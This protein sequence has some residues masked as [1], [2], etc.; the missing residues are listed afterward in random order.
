MLK[1]RKILFPFAFI[2]GL[3]TFVRNV[4]YDI[5]ILKSH[6]FNVPTI[7]VGNLSVGGTGKSPQV[8]YLIKLLSANYQV[9]TLSRGYKR[10]T[11]GFVLA[12]DKATAKIIGDE[13][14]QFYSKF[15]KTIVAVDEKR[16]EGIELLM[17]L[18]KKPDVIILDDA[19]QHRSVKAGFYIL[20]TAYNDLFCD[21]FMLPSGNLREFEAGKKRSDVVVV[22]KCPSNL[23]EAS[24]KRIISRLKVSV[25]VYFTSIFYDDFV[26]NQDDKSIP[27]E[28]IINSE[29]I[30]VAGIANPE[31]FFK[32]LSAKKTET[33]TF[34]DHHSFDTKDLQ[35]IINKAAGKKIITT[36]KDFVRLKNKVPKEQLYYLPIQTK[37][38]NNSEDFDQMITAYVQQSLSQ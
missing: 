4:L 5:K 16:A 30:V 18:D 27:I 9:A 21:D 2:Y 12:N 35:L 17:N 7:A 8:E 22:T 13:P 25:P 11:S 31:P 36:E 3:I 38:L 26:Y 15:P 28:E 24:Q 23:D 6:V 1:I 19:F 10:S 20:L 29:K 33:I 34:S 37:F 14:F 32:F